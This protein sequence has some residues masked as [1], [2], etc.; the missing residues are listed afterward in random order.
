MVKS[1]VGKTY[2]EWLKPL[3]LLSPEKRRLRGGLIVAHGFLMMGNAGTGVKLCSLFDRNRTQGNSMKLQ[4]E[5]VRLDITKMFFTKRVVRHWNR[6]P[7]EVVMTTSL[8]EFKKCL[9][10]TLRYVV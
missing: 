3:C 10:H 4:Q 8:L 5:R 7:R 2:E 9:D 1:L 6:L